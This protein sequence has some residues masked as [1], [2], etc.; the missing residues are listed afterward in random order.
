MLLSAFHQT[1]PSC[2]IFLQGKYIMKLLPGPPGAGS[3]RN[4]MLKV[5]LA[6]RCT[7]QLS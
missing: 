1:A 6:S 3:L 7:Q 5:L 4:L 2:S